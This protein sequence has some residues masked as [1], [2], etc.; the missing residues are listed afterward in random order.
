MLLVLVLSSAAS[1]ARDCVH[2]HLL[3]KGLC[4]EQ[5]LGSASGTHT[6]T[7][8]V[9]VYVCLDWGASGTDGCLL[10]TCSL[11]PRQELATP[12]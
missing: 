12:A 7:H 3:H 2:L 1:A 6:H 9:C 10:A 8:D 11:K 4:T 5:H